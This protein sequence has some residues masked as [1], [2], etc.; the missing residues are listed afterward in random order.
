VRS[1][2]IGR[3]RA[4]RADKR[5]KTLERTYGEISSRRGD[6]RLGT[7]RKASGRSLTKMVRK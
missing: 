2:N 4:K 3:F 6:T 1:K 7:L 5:L